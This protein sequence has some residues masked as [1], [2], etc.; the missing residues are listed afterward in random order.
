MFWTEGLS[1]AFLRN[2]DDYGLWSVVVA[3]ILYVFLVEE[4]W[5]HHTSN[6]A[7][8]V[9]DWCK[10]KGELVSYLSPP[11]KDSLYRVIKRYALLG[12]GLFFIQNRF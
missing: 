5:P 10:E 3:N 12:N 4:F 9:D 6:P 2:F 11:S 7:V 1:S 8:L